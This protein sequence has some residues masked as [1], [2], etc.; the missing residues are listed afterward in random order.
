MAPKSKHNQGASAQTPVPPRSNHLWL[1]TGASQKSPPLKLAACP[2]AA[3][4]FG[5]TS[6]AQDLSSQPFPKASCVSPDVSLLLCIASTLLLGQ[7]SAAHQGWGPYAPYRNHPGTISR[8]ESNLCAGG[9]SR[10]AALCTPTNG[11]LGC[12]AKVLL[13]V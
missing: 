8:G 13:S 7:S 6:A 2:G 3:G 9:E 5:A 12:K 11:V 1:N 4:A 10:L